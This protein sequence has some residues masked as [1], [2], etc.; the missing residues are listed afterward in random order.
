MLRKP[1]RGGNE[2]RRFNFDI[3]SERNR[4]QVVAFFDRRG[5]SFDRRGESFDRRGEGAGGGQQ[6][7]EYGVSHDSVSY[8]LTAGVYMP[9]VQDEPATVI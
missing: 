8:R 6:E 4:G 5:E 1:G 2:F 9:V 7:S 3:S